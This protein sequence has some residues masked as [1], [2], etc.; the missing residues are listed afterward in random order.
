[1]MTT[2]LVKLILHVLPKYT[3]YNVFIERLEVG[4]SVGDCVPANSKV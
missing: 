3:K 2:V 4:R 1:M